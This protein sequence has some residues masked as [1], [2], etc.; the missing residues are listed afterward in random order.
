MKI[1]IYEDVNEI[2]EDVSQIFIELIKQKSNAVLGMATGSSPVGVYVKLVEAY[3]RGQISFKEI[4]NFN[5]DE[6][7]GIDVNHPQSYYNFMKEN[8][9]KHVDPT[10]ENLY[11][12]IVKGDDLQKVCDEYNELLEKHPRDI[13]ILGIGSNGHIA[14]N[15]PG[16][17][18]S[19][20]T[21]V[22]NLKESTIKDNARFFKTKDEVPTQAI[23]MGLDN[24][25]NSK[26]IVLIAKG[27]NKAWAV[28]EMIEGKKSIDCPAT[29][30]Q[31][32][33][34]VEIFLDKDAASMLEKNYD[35]N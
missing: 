18:F 14:F 16:T 21:H 27:K 29:I 20:V 6:Y 9:Y 3:R 30:L 10:I 23:S 15:E 11:I 19:E 13:Q 35:N 17:D 34:D 2:D 25:M 32:H 8:L 1:K 7:V 26:K 24:I 33:K 22:T 31:D 12:P 4:Y 5:L 28:K